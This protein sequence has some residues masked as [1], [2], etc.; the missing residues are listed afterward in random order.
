MRELVLT[1][2]IYAFLAVLALTVPYGWLISSVWLSAG[3]YMV[4]ETRSR[5]WIADISFLAT[6]PIYLALGR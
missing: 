5:G 6:W 3:V 4:L 2:A 1:I